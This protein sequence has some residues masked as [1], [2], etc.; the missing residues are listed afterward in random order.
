MNKQTTIDVLHKGIQM[1]KDAN[2]RVKTYL[3]YDYPGETEEDRDL[4]VEFIRQAQPDK[5]TVSKF[6]ALPGAW[7]SQFVPKGE[8]WF[9]PDEDLGFI[10]FRERIK[11][12]LE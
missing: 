2:I 11:E 6:R 12:A 4:T 3:M 10:E 5:F 8:Q 1:I 9:Y 7:I